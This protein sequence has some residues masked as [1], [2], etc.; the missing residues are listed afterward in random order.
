MKSLFVNLRA[1]YR[2]R[3]E[4]QRRVRWIKAWIDT[5]NAKVLEIGPLDRPLVPRSGANQVKYADVMSVEE[6]KAYVANNPRRDVN[7]IVPLDYVLAGRPVAEVI[8]ESFDVVIT[9]HVLEHVPDFLGYLRDIA[10]L[11]NPGGLL[12]ADLPDRRYTYDL[13]R[14]FTSIGEFIE[15]HD[16]HLSKPS[17]RSAFDQTHYHRDVLAGHLWR[18]YEGTRAASKPTFHL[19]RAWAQ[20]ERSQQDYVDTHCNLFSPESFKETIT[21]TRELGFHGF[22]IVRFR[23]TEPRQLDFNA[24]LQLDGNGGDAGRFLKG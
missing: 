12:Y 9:S 22:H 15:N 2:R 1:K 14:P 23:D 21:V 24:L 11:L 16:L 17:P 5:A 18:D 7:K 6:L 8:K 3:A 13:M 10:A 20:F 4:M 19:S